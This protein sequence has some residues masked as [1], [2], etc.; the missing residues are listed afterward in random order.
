M[1][2]N[3]QLI[4]LALF[5]AYHNEND[6]NFKFILD[7]TPLAELN[8]GIVLVTL[9]AFATIGAAHGMTVSQ[10]IELF[11]QGVLQAQL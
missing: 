3:P 1:T 2:A 8:Q 7:T 10:V 11:R 4:A 9:G 6:E 5:E